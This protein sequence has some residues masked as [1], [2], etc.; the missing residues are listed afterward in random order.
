MQEFPN[1]THTLRFYSPVASQYYPSVK[2]WTGADVSCLSCHS[3]GL[4]CRRESCDGFRP[5][6]TT[7]ILDKI[8]ALG[9]PDT[10]AKSCRAIR[11]IIHHLVTDKEDAFHRVQGTYNF[12]STSLS[13][14]M[15]FPL[16]PSLLCFFVP[17]YFKKSSAE[18]GQ[19]P[20]P[21]RHKHKSEL[22]TNEMKLC[23]KVVSFLFSGV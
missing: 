19:R 17:Q 3:A 15:S 2:R 9:F 12:F 11:T 20:Q 22:L 21:L 18:I 1:M 23:V 4:S 14:L 13:H 6:T 7:E 8:D 10:T 5:R 16:F